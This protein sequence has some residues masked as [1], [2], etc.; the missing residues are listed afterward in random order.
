MLILLGMR[1]VCN[2]VG[3]CL[4]FLGDAHK[5]CQSEKTDVWDLL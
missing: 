5:V 1:L 4:F 2:Y 3:K